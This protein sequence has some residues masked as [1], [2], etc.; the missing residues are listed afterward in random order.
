[1]K[2]LFPNCFFFQLLQVFSLFFLSSP[3]SLFI[4]LSFLPLFYLSFPIPLISFYF[5]FCYFRFCASVQNTLPFCSEEEKE[6][7]KKKKEQEEIRKEKKK[8]E[9]EKRKEMERNKN[10][11]SKEEHKV[12]YF[13][14]E[15]H[16]ILLLKLQKK[17]PPLL[18]K[19]GSL[20][21]K[22][23]KL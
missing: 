6:H 14:V 21:K 5:L 15:M 16:L 8:E 7:N 10:L 19:A 2:F 20:R 1:M 4:L 22:N 13:I 18:V 11:W 12:T 23:L 3:S 17:G 9:E